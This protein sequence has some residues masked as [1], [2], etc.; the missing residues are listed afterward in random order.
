M[1][2]SEL[3]AVD[4]DTRLRQVWEDLFEGSLWELVIKA[5]PLDCRTLGLGP[6]AGRGYVYSSSPLLGRGPRNELGS[7]LRWAYGRGYADR[8]REI[9]AGLPVTLGDDAGFELA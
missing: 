1:A 9:A 8:D 3:L 4:I 6:N 5:E 7:Y 2:N